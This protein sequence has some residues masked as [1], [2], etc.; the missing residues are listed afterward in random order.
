[1]YQTK[2]P[3]EIKVDLSKTDVPQ[4]A[5]QSITPRRTEICGICG[6]PEPVNEVGEFKY[7]CPRKK[8]KD[9]I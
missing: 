8:K 7:P 2:Y 1:M 4:Y 5:Y 6:K 9:M 3:Q